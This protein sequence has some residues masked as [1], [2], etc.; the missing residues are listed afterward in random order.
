MKGDALEKGACWHLLHPSAMLALLR[1]MAAERQA[2]A[3]VYGPRNAIFLSLVHLCPQINRAGSVTRAL[4]R[5]TSAEYL[6]GDNKYKC[7]QQRRMVRA[8]KRMTIEVRRCFD[9]QLNIGF[10]LYRTS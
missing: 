5:F 1:S 9:C 3:E 7:P 6:E 8:A 4:Q 2:A 10:K